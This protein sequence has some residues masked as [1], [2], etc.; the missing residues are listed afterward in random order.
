MIAAAAAEARQQYRRRDRRTGLLVAGGL[1]AM[2]AVAAFARHSSTKTESWVTGP[3]RRIEPRLEHPAADVYK[4][5]AVPRG[6]GDSHL[7]LSYDGLAELQ[8]KG[9]VKLLA[10]RLLVQ[11]A[12]GLA[13][14]ALA[15][16]PTDPTLDNER[17]V[18]ALLEKRPGDAVHFLEHA[19]A[20]SPGSLPV[21]WN[22]ALALRDLGLGYAA[23]ATFS[24]V[25]AN[26]EHGWSQEAQRW[27]ALL[28]MTTDER[29]RAY[30]EA[31]AEARRMVTAQRA[32]SAPVIDRFPE[33]VRS[34]FYDAVRAAPSPESLERLQAPARALDARLR[35]D[36]FAK[37][38]TATQA[39]DFKQ[40]A[41]LAA[42]YA[43]LREG[44][45]KEPRP[46]FLADYV[47][48]LRRAGAPASDLL[49]GVLLSVKTGPAAAGELLRSAATERDPWLA[50]SAL[51]EAARVDPDSAVKGSR[52]RLLDRAL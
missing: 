39:M 37:L 18:V 23:A 17:A 24:A 35:V 25:A 6:N 41:P 32:P 12:N 15:G 9:A 14:R 28:K 42:T 2:V 10:D 4:P 1:L 49:L 34:F 19:L 36:L 29:R 21:M 33:V 40:R 27:A 31:E 52:E 3:S 20:R 38:V 5:Y 26:G 22:R 13:S 45:W 16:A 47:T 48:S 7:G 51:Q 11:R 30:E 43:R 46:G 50:V 44:R 8:T